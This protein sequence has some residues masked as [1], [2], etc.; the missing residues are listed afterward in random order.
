[1]GESSFIGPEVK[2]IT[3]TESEQCRRNRL[4]C[5]DP[6]NL[7]GDEDAGQVT[8]VTRV[9]MKISES[10]GPPTWAE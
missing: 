10:G 8:Y 4:T 6:E 9:E 3:N 7:T 2:E 5:G 1:M